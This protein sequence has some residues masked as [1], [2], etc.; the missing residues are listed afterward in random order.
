[1]AA[2][3]VEFGPKTL[4]AIQRLTDALNGC[5]AKNQDVDSIWLSAT[6][7][8]KMIGVSYQTFLN[9]VRA[10]RVP[11]GVHISARNTRWKKSELLK[12]EVDA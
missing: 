4:E 5:G 6:E 8:A 9:L 11:Q 10:G 2:I 12:M 1:M 3:D 7:A